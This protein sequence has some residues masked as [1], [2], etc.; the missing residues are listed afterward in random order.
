MSHILQSPSV[1]FECAGGACV[2]D[3]LVGERLLVAAKVADPVASR[4]GRGRDVP[5]DGGLTLT[6]HV[7]HNTFV[8]PV[9]PTEAGMTTHTQCTCIHGEQ[10]KHT[11][12]DMH[13]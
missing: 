6:Q 8:D 11:T 1:H 4:G 2:R 3:D 9:E 12:T 13:K 7:L 5:L 10:G